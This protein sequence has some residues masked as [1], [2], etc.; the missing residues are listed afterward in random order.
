MQQTNQILNDRIDAGHLMAG[1]LERY[2]DTD[3]LVLAVPRGGVVVGYQVA[4]GL[5]LPLDVVVPRKLGA[6]GDP[7]LA[8]GAV[9]PWGNSEP[10]LDEATIDFFGVSGDY[11]ASETQAQLAEI[12]RRL[13]E[14][15]GTTHPPDV[16]D[17]TVVIVDDGIAT[18]YTIQAAIEAIKRLEPSKTILAVPVAAPEPV[19][20]LSP[21][22]NEIYTILT[23]SPF[24]AVGHW[25]R[26]FAQ[27]TDRE[28]V[29]LLK[30]RRGERK[31]NH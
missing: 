18:G 23:P 29:E 15:R 11:I 8:I 28:V 17:K 21:L 31:H 26:N 14:Y 16:R 20:R 25:Y 5:R 22:V 9:A 2:K 6:P 3:S 19:R 1:L 4:R 24:R 10:F 30:H 12:D 13:N 7:E 27:T